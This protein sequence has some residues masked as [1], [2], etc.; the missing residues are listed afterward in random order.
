MHGVVERHHVG[1]DLTSLEAAGAAEQGQVRRDREH[2]QQPPGGWMGHYDRD[3]QPRGEQAQAQI[4]ESFH[5]LM[6]SSPQSYISVSMTNSLILVVEDD[7]RLAATLERVLVAEGHE[8]ARAGDGMQAL[9]RAK[10]RPPDLVIL[11]VLLPGLDGIGVCRR[12]RSTGQFPILMLT[13]L[14]GTE[15]RVRGLDAGADDY[16]VKPFAY[17][18]L[19]ARVRALLRRTGPVDHLRFADLVLEP[20][21]RG[22]WRGT[23][24]LSLTQTEFTLLEHFLR[25]PRQVLTREQLLEAV[26]AGEPESDNVVA[27]YIGYVRQKLEGGGEPRLLHTVRGSGYALRE[28]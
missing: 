8:V 26:W 11:D 13:A 3:P 12:L 9:R 28:S 6:E 2:D 22:A 19:L 15:D 14:D 4:S 7:A 1:L 18:E 10:E 16:L 21:S 17:Q 27:V 20:A 25:H 23:R 24:S 5:P